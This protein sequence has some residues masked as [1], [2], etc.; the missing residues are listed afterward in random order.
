MAA[1]AKPGAS[2]PY[3]AGASTTRATYIVAAVASFCWL[4]DDGSALSAAR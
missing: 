2:K 4:V 1:P 3:G